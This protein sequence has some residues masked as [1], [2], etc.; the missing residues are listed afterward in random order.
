MSTGVT[1]RPARSISRVAQGSERA[2]P[3]AFFGSSRLPEFDSLQI[4]RVADQEGAAPAGQVFG[5]DDASAQVRGVRLPAPLGGGNAPDSMAT[6]SSA[7]SSKFMIHTPASW[8][9][10]AARLLRCLPPNSQAILPSTR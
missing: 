5:F 7:S 9:S 10:Q 2:P 8:L 4:H 3:R 6:R 1:R